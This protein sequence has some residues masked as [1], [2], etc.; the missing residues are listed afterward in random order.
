[1]P[2]LAFRMKDSIAR[3]VIR[4]SQ[5]D[6][7]A[8]QEREYSVDAFG[9]RNSAASMP[10]VLLVEDNGAPVTVFSFAS[11]ALLFAGQ[12][13]FEFRGYLKSCGGEIN[14]V[15]FR[16]INRLAYHVT[17]IGR[18]GGLDYY[19]NEVRRLMNSLGG[20][21]NIAIG[22]SSGGS[23]AL[24]FG[25]RCGM[26]KVIAF[27]PPFP[28][29]CWIG[30]LSHIRSLLDWKLL[31]ASPYD[32]WEVAF[33]GLTSVMFTFD[34][35][36]KVGIASVFDPIKTYKDAKPRPKATVF[37]GAECRPDRSVALL[38][39]DAPEVTLRP[40]PTG[41]H[42]IGL[43]LAKKGELGPAILREIEEAI[44]STQA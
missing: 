20:R 26:D 27:S 4:L 41:R 23:A 2:G 19:E 38:L 10:E 22:D 44:T 37:Y 31:L 5:P 3:I 42:N 16:D 14:R 11:S 7:G 25:A 15:F 29:R 24:Y 9:E 18:P 6:L 35:V 33:I 40:V 1:M 28:L 43:V 8:E 13:T 12:P 34:L 17:P 30:P 39:S 21:T 36:M 32:Y